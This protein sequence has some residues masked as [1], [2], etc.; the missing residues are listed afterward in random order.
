MWP[1]AGASSGPRSGG[2]GERCQ[3]DTEVAGTFTDFQLLPRQMREF[4]LYRHCRR[5]PLVLE[6][7]GLC[8]GP[9]RVRL[10][11]AVKSQASSFDRR[12][13]IRQT[14][15]A[16]GGSGVRLLFLLGLQR[17]PELS[18]LLGCESRRHGDLLQWAFL[19]TFFNL[20]LKEVLFL[21]WL[22]RRCPGAHFIF[23]GDD[24]TFVNTGGLLHLL[25]GLG[26]AESRE[27]FIGDLILG[28]RPCRDP[29]LKYYVPGAF[30]S[31]LYPPY[32]GGAGVLYSGRLARRLARVSHSV[33]LFPIDDVYAGMCLARLGVPPRHHPG[34]CSF[35]LGLNV[36]D[37][38]DPCV[39]RRLLVVHRRSPQEIVHLWR[40]LHQA[41]VSCQAGPSDLG[42]EWPV[43]GC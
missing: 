29:A 23:K 5:Y 13:A 6:P 42:L 20:T 38:W 24:D 35:G 9:G 33:P 15:G 41:N 37:P 10:L 16:S 26:P 22:G 1:G 2:R 25:S 12:Q 30:Y 21:A 34:F 43:G 18:G 39:Y 14:W 36:T 11:L 17:Q 32:A 3:A 40:L 31:G 8:R 4:L 19:D 7:R 27:L 28:A